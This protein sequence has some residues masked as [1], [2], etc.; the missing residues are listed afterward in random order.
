MSTSTIQRSPLFKA[1]VIAAPTSNVANGERQLVDLAS[2]GMYPGIFGSMAAGGYQTEGDAVHV[3]ADGTDPNALWAEFQATLEIFNLRRQSIVN[4]LTFPVA[5]LIET[6]PTVGSV[7]FERATEFGVP[8]AVAIEQ[9]FFQMGYDFQDYD[10]ATRYTWKYL[11]DADIRQV[12]ALHNAILEAD[13]RLIFKKVMEALFDNRNRTADIRNQNY[14]VYALYNADGTVPPSYKNNTFQGDHSHYL[15]SGA[16]AIDSQDLE[17]AVTHIA[18]HGYGQEQGTQFVHVMNSAQ[19]AVVR[20]FR[21]GVTINGVVCNYD[22]IPASNQ[23]ALFIPN[24]EGLLGSQPPTS[25]QGLPV[26]GSYGNALIVE[27]DYI[28]ANYVLT[29]GSGGSGN[30]QNP[31]GLREHANP[32]YRGL[33]LLPGNQQRYPLVDSYYARAFGTGIRQR[34]GSVITEIRNTATDA[35]PYRI[36]AAYDR[37]KG[38]G[39]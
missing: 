13:N 11:R 18:H 12:Q 35:G 24:A 37:T 3:L 34:G 30:L 29:L 21:Q 36:P 15:V 31:V 25:W 33:R 23:P 28:P 20:T 38:V 1:S 22:F 7:D 32:A 39:A 4:V 19:T 16:A 17:S 26:I 10:L 6:V 8:K 14:N 9:D 2:L 5:N 27:E